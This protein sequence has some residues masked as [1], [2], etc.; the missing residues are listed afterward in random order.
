MAGAEFDPDRAQGVQGL[1]FEDLAFSYTVE[2]GIAGGAE[3]ERFVFFWGDVVM[4]ASVVAK[5]PQGLILV[6]PAESA[7]LGMQEP[8]EL[9]GASTTMTVPAQAAAGM[10]TVL[11]VEGRPSLAQHLFVSPRT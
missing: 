4:E 10:L 8:S 1:V 6:V 9:I 7:P 2:F 5:R 3:V 11:V